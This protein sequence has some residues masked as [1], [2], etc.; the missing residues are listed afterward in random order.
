[1]VLA[2]LWALVTVDTG[3]PDKIAQ[4]E[5]AHV[6]SGACRVDRRVQVVIQMVDALRQ[7]SVYVIQY[8]GALIALYSNVVLEPQ[9][10]QIN[11]AEIALQ[12]P[13]KVKLVKV[14]ACYA[15]KGN[16]LQRAEQSQSQYAGHALRIHILIFPAVRVLPTARVT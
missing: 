10:L 5:F 2:H 13:L 6:V 7:E 16:I 9:S 8:G 4:T 15:R 3:G 11:L 14:G 12:E 1:M